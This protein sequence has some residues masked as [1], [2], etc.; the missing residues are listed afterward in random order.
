MGFD[1]EINKEH[2]KKM[3]HLTPTQHK[4]LRFILDYQRHHHVPPTNDEMKD[5]LNMSNVSTVIRQLKDDGWI[6]REGKSPAHH[7]ELLRDMPDEP[8][9]I[10]DNR[11]VDAILRR[12][13]DT[14]ERLRGIEGILK[15]MM[16]KQGDDD[17]DS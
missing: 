10:E 16:I 4:V 2:E 13:D 3:K 15:S 17:D 6:K 1:K 8:E 12:L 5:E 7:Y 14:E 11:T 9:E